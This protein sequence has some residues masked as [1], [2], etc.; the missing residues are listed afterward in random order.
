MH[1]KFDRIRAPIGIHHPDGLI[2][3]LLVKREQID[4]FLLVFDKQVIESHF[5]SFYNKPI[6]MFEQAHCLRVLLG[7]MESCNGQHPH[8]SRIFSKY[9]HK[10]VVSCCV[11]DIKIPVFI[12]KTH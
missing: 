10:K 9:I 6:A 8:L 4:Y 7:R 5:P 3:N 2:R 11:A 1:T 12:S